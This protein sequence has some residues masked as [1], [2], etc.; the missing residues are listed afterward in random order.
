[1]L[2]ACLCPRLG[3]PQ[4]QGSGWSSARDPELERV[5]ITYVLEKD[6]LSDFDGRRV[7]IRKVC[8]IIQNSKQRLKILQELAQGMILYISQGDVSESGEC[9]KKTWT[10][11]KHGV[12]DHSHVNSRIWL[13]GVQVLLRHSPLSLTSP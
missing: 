7:H 2:V 12:S 3:A 13:V 6:F 1:M 8:R 10:P 5:P 9:L 4:G 11:T